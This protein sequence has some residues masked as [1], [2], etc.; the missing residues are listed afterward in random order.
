MFAIVLL[1]MNTIGQ[2]TTV[3]DIFENSNRI[4]T[5]SPEPKYGNIN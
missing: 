5:V 1:V 4:L 2:D 3:F